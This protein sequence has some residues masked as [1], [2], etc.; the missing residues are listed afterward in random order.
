M[1]QVKKE[2]IVKLL[3]DTVTRLKPEGAL[4]LS[5]I[6]T[7]R[8]A[9]INEALAENRLV[10]IERLMIGDWLGLAVKHAP[11]AIQESTEA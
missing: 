6:I 2:I 3:P 1:L 4:L 9:I 7:E 11:T 5:G 10:V 8:E